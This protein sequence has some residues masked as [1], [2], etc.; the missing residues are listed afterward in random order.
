[1]AISTSLAQQLGINSIL[2][3][4]TQLSETQQQISLGKRILKP[5][6][7]PAG[8]VKL[9]DLNQ[10]ISRNTQFQ[11]N[12]DVAINSLSQ[13]EG[14]LQG[15]TA[16]LQR[17]RELTVQG[18][19]DTNTLLDKASIAVEISEQLDQ[20]IALAN[21]QDAEGNYLFAGFKTN[22]K[23]VTGD[24]TAGGF[25]YQGDDNQR[26]L[27]IG[28]N[29]FITD[30]NPGSEIFFDLVD[31][32]GNPE[33][34][35]TTVFNLASDLSSNRP[36]YEEMLVTTSAQP[37]DGE[38]VTIDGLT[39][40]FD[41]GGGVGAG[42]IAVTIGGTTDATTTNLAN[43]I[44][45][46]NLAGNTTVTASAT[47]SDLTLV[48][49]IEGAGNLT[50]ADGTG[51]DLTITNPVSI[52]LYDHL[53]QLDVILDNVLAVRATVGARLN[54]L[55]NQNEINQDLLVSVKTIKSQT[56]DLDMAEAISRFN[57][58]IVSLQ[59][60]QQA[61]VRVQGLSLFNQL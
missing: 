40:E 20:L 29:R 37:A 5:S 31:R 47:A 28:E 46:E 22:A 51:G 11:E 60:A 8:T 1:M 17:I 25:S 6:D 45:A 55:D 4:Q 32:N 30:H 9:L 23:P 59:A 19:N 58:Q 50:Y 61:F 41:S 49:G 27:Q 10:A 3:Q 14:V 24:A 48:A 16:A 18:F 54:V 43:A 26:L 44:N 12:L 38:T 57:L 56:E 42:N 15:V 13:G 36:A 34:M 52:P 21:S 33:D 39:Y 7:D 2:F 53:D 35:F